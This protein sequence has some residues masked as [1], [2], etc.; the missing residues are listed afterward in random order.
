MNHLNGSRR[1]LAKEFRELGEILDRL[2]SGDC[3]PPPWRIGQAEVMGAFFHLPEGNSQ[4]GSIRV[5][6]DPVFFKCLPV[7]STAAE[8]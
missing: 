6:R 8:E 1:S 4:A 7:S 3:G 2:E 5:D